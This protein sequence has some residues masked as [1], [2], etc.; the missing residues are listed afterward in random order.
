MPVTTPVAPPCS[1]ASGPRGNRRALHALGLAA[2]MLAVPVLM[3]S[4]AFAQSSGARKEDNSCAQYGAG[5][6]RVPGSNSCV[7]TGASVRTDAYSGGAPG[8]AGG[9]FNA[10]TSGTTG[11]SAPSTDAWKSAR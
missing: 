2:A 9:Q 3:A 10:P 4:A 1:A 6:Q 8:N 5:F 7:R 11:T